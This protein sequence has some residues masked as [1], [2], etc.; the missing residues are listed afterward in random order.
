MIWTLIFVGITI[1]GIVLFLLDIGNVINDYDL[2]SLVG[3]IGFVL[4]VFGALISIIML[5]I[6]FIAHVTSG[7]DIQTKRIEYDGL[8]KRL[9]IVNSEFE[10]VSKSDVI[11]DITEWNKDIYSA[12]YWSESKWTNWFWDKE[13]VDS[14]DYIEMED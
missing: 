9:E 4:S 12:K 5:A 3:C 1:L 14:L 7:H 2:S 10:D 11:K 13:Y 6:I 8:T